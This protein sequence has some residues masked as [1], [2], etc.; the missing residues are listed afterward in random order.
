MCG[1]TSPEKGFVPGKVSAENTENRQAPSW[2]KQFIIVFVITVT[3][4]EHAR[5]N[6]ES[7][8]VSL[9]TYTLSHS[10]PVI[11]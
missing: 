3:L 7:S 1:H 9:G 5:V 8:N 2:K 4:W 10:P 11:Q 6:T